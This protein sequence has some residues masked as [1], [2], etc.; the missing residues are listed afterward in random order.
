MKFSRA[1]F[2][3]NVVRENADKVVRI[4]SRILMAVLIM[5]DVTFLIIDISDTLPRIL[6]TILV[7]FPFERAF[8]VAFFALRTKFF[9]VIFNAL[10]SVRQSWSRIAVRGLWKLTKTMMD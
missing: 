8:L 10:T 5:Y 3:W 9:R 7:N 6:S 1:R 4:I 2:S